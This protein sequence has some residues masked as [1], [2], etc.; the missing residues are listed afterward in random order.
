MS[1]FRPRALVLALLSLCAAAGSLACVPVPVLVTPPVKGQIKDAKTGQPVAGAVVV[2]RFDA[3]YDDLLPDRDVIE[4]R[5]LVSAADGSFALGRSAVATFAL[6]PLVRSE[7]RVV[8]VIADGYRCPDPQLV[9]DAGVSVALTPALDDDDRRDS[10]RPVGAK[11]GEAPRYLAAWESLHPRVDTHAQREQN[12]ELERVLEARGVFGFGENCSGPIVDLALSPDGQH[13]AWMLA[14][15]NA[16]SVQIR[17][18]AAPAARSAPVS[19][20]QAR[21]GRRLAWTSQG[22]L[23]LWEPAGELERALSPSRLSPSGEGTEVVWRESQS[24]PP[25]SQAERGAPRPL[26]VEPADLRDEGDA[27]WLGRSFRIAR[28]L[29]PESGLPRERLRVNSGSQEAQSFVLPGEPCGPHGEFGQPQLRIAADTRTAFDLRDTGAGCGVVSVDLQT[30]EWSRVDGARGGRCEVERR[31]PATHFR[32]AMRGYAGDVTEALMHAGADAS[33]AFSL[34][35]APDGS[36]TAIS[37]DVRGELVRVAVP[38]FP[39]RTPLRKVEVGVIGPSRGTGQAPV[40]R[41]EPL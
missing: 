6:W 2:V 18:T 9:S 36:T 26:P 27:R 32:T 22:E 33:A 31:V 34:R 17:S 30:G 12:R 15:G 3:R 35:I 23:L 40:P 1:E 16:F 5:E 19:I 4:H 21:P 28:E 29:D 14:D 38:R 37:Q 25:A 24:A 11:A 8:G 39:M 10:C 7:A 41:L 20:S 13:V